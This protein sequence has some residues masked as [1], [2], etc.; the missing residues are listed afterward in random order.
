M[1]KAGYDCHRNMGDDWSAC[2]C[3]VLPFF[4]QLPQKLAA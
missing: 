1:L 4:S 3:K 2:R